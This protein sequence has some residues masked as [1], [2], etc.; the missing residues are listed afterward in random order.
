MGINL[1]VISPH[2]VHDYSLPL[3]LGGALNWL[4][5]LGRRLEEADPAVRVQVVEELWPVLVVAGVGRLEL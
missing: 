5:T 3:H 2:R 1:T 4:P